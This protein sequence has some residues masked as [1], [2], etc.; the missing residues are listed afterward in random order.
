METCY[1][2]QGTAL[3]VLWYPIRKKN[4]KKYIYIPGS[5]IKLMPYIYICIYIHIYIYEDIDMAVLYT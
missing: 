2:A 4:L 5:G 1:T 3:D